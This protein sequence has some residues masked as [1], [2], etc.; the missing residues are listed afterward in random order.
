N[1]GGQLGETGLRWGYLYTNLLDYKSL[2]NTGC[3]RQKSGQIWPHSFSDYDSAAEKLTHETTK[4][5]YHITYAPDLESQIVCTCGKPG[6]GPCVEHEAAWRDKYTVNTG[7]V[8]DATAYMTLE[9]AASIARLTQ[10]NLDL[11]ERLTALETH[12]TQLRLTQKTPE[13]NN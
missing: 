8:I 3:E 11:E 9:H 12:L 7:A 1:N 5:K 13:V 2:S 6:T 10:Q 4:T